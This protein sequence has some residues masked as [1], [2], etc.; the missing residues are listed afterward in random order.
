MES[1]K[2]STDESYLGVIFHARETDRMRTECKERHRNRGMS[3]GAENY[4]HG[5]GMFAGAC[6]GDASRFMIRSDQDQCVLVL[7]GKVKCIFHRMIE[8]LNPLD[9]GAGIV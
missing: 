8:M 7:E 3:P 2:L 5:I 4:I 9:N 6:Q 1:E